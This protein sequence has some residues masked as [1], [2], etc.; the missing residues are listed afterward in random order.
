[1]NLPAR[2]IT[3]LLAL[4]FVAL[5]VVTTNENSQKAAARG[6][7]Q[8][9]DAPWPNGKW[10]V[11]VIPDTN[12]KAD[13]SVPVIVSRTTTSTT[14]GKDNAFE[15]VI[16][17]NRSSKAVSEVKLRYVIHKIEAPDTI[18]YQGPQFE[19]KAKKGNEK[20]PLQ[21]NKRWVFDVP[22]G[23]LARFLKPV[24]KDGSLSGEFVIRVSVDEV[25]FEDGS[26]WKG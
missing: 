3:C 11:S 10:T 7:N 13:A 25:T 8:D 19:I 5:C 22:N 26:V 24:V 16:L 23:R 15:H 14:K 9:A 17:L 4:I 18:L 6:A 1:M 2:N 12:Q 21:A 20:N